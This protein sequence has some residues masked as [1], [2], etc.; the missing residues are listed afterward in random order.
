MYDFS[1]LFNA[2]VGILYIITRNFTCSKH[3]EFGC[4]RPRCQR[5]CRICIEPIEISY[6]FGQNAEPSYGHRAVYK[7]RFTRKDDLDKAL[8]KCRNITHSHHDLSD[9]TCEEYEY[10]DND[11]YCSSEE[12]EEESEE[13]GEVV[14]LVKLLL[15]ECYFILF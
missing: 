14:P 6:T 11:G 7:I 12:S 5:K 10:S 8:A 15:H 2:L 1:T 13:E 9:M 3:G 4:M